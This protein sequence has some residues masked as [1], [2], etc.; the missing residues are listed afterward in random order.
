M[1]AYLALF[2]SYS[3]SFNT[4]I[5]LLEFNNIDELDNYTRCFNNSKE[6]KKLFQNDVSEFVL[7][8]RF[9]KGYKE[10]KSGIPII[11]LCAYVYYN[12]Y[13]RFIPIMYKNEDI[14]EDR[15][16]DVICFNLEKDDIFNKFIRDYDYLL[17][18]SCEVN[19]LKRQYFLGNKNVKTRIIDIF[20][21][22]LSVIS[23]IEKQYYLR[24]LVNVCNLKII[25]EN[26]NESDYW[27]NEKEYIPSFDE[28]VDEEC[29]DDF[30]R[31]LIKEENYEEIFNIYSLD[32]ILVYSINQKKPIGIRR[33]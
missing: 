20:I 10:T 33:N 25:K 2:L 29:D 26:N 31:K 3:D 8:C 30:F 19:T 6:I 12:N 9:E 22:K 1:K 18:Y 4:R 11:R 13:I 16:F 15:I 5:N 21:E 32:K 14:I 17:G 27:K 23:K 24:T 7:E 28:K